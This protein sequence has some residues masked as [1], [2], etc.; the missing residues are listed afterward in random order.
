MLVK[1]GHSDDCLLYQP[2]KVSQPQNLALQGNGWRSEH[3]GLYL[4]IRIEKAC[5]LS[6]SSEVQQQE[7]TTHKTGKAGSSDLG[8]PAAKVKMSEHI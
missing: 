4:S 7:A 3:L 5:T 8:P 1:D 2:Q 6:L